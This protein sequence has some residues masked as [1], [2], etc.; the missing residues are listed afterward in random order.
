MIRFLGFLINH[1]FN[2]AKTG[3]IIL[4]ISLSPITFTHSL[5]LK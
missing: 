5:L 3:R 1:F 4:S 2:I